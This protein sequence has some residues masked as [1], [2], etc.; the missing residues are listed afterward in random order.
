MN[1]WYKLPFLLIP[2]CKYE[3]L[4]CCWTELSKHWITCHR[5]PSSVWYFTVSHYQ[6]ADLVKCG[7]FLCLLVVTAVVEVFLPCKEVLLDGSIILLIQG[8]L[9]LPYVTSTY[10]YRI[11]PYKCCWGFFKKG[12]HLRS[13]SIL[14]FDESKRC[15]NLQKWIQDNPINDLQKYYRIKV[16]SFIIQLSLAITMILWL[17]FFLH[18][19]DW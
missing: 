6:A 7:Y 2:L 17:V 14:F 9:C 19:T 15:F 16:I 11:K 4:S 12:L 18:F 5:A 3:E 13:K 8:G 10:S 1:H